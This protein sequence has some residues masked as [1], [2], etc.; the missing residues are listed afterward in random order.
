MLLLVAQKYH[1]V[2][3]KR[4][5]RQLAQGIAPNRATVGRQHSAR[6]FIAGAVSSVVSQNMD[7]VRKKSV[8]DHSYSCVSD[9]ASVVGKV[10]PSKVLLGR[11]ILLVAV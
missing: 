1:N 4:P 2:A 9:A 8:R 6:Y 3:G 11:K 5:A 7:K 10:I